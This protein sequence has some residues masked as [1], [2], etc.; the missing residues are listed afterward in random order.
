V[1]ALRFVNAMPEPRGRSPM[2]GRRGGP[3]K[4]NERGKKW[5]M[6]R[7]LWNVRRSEGK[8][9]GEKMPEPGVRSR[10]QASWWSPSHP[11]WRDGKRIL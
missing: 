7:L 5:S 8:R 1:G 10:A 9:A 4:E 3:P 11:F 6:K 2:P